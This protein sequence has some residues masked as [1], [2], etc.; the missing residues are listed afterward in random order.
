M[1]VAKLLVLV[2]LLST[3]RHVTEAVS[4]LVGPPPT[5]TSFSA[6]FYPGAPVLI[7]PS[8]V[9]FDSSVAP[10]SSIQISL[11]PASNPAIEGISFSTLGSYYYQFA[12]VIIVLS[13]LSIID[14]DLCK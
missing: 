3:L 7:L 5:R 14:N 9:A 8:S 6:T 13:F 11:Q 2:A 4:L 1:M 12:A 10:V